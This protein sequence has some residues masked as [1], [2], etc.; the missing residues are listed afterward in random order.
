MTSKN[1][2][3]A[4]ALVLEGCTEA[5]AVEAVACHEGLALASD[6]G[7]HTFRVASDCANAVRSIHGE[8]FGRYIGSNCSR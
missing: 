1:S 2:C 3:K 4:S 7:L 8:G 6:I 5:E